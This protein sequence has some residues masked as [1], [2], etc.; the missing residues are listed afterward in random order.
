MQIFVKPTNLV[1][2]NEMMHTLTFD[3]NENELVS[4]L[5]GKILRRLNLPVHIYL[6]YSGKCLE[7]N[8]KISDYFITKESTILL[9]VKPI[10]Y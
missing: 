8:K 1:I 5:L 3:I 6:I 2:N 4:S 7:G 9:N 10:N